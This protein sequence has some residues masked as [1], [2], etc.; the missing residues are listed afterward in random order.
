MVGLVDDWGACCQQTNG[1]RDD[2]GEEE[3][4]SLILV[5][6]LYIIPKSR[7]GEDVAGVFDK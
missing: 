3:A 1:R 5:W 2:M 4:V 7:D 6:Q